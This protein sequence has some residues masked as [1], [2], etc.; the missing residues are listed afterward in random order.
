M[1]GSPDITVIRNTVMFSIVE[2]PRV[3]FS[4][5]S[6]GIRNTNLDRNTLKGTVHGIFKIPVRFTTVLFKSLSYLQ[7]G[8]YLEIRLQQY[9]F[10][11][12]AI[13][14]NTLISEIAMLS[15][16]V[17]PLGLCLF[18]IVNEKTLNLEKTTS[19]VLSVLLFIYDLDSH[20]QLIELV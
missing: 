10:L 14:L 7:R 19:S 18:V 11:I 2:I 17:T 20:R 13:P 8:K 1:G 9:S 4:P 16:R 5:D 6:A 12:F 15:M 3:I